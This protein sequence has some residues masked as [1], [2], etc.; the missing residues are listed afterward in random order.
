MGVSNKVAS[1]CK[2]LISW[3]FSKVVPPG[4]LN[5]EQKQHSDQNS[6]MRTPLISDDNK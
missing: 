4:G 2:S 1:D 3:N 6:W 5:T